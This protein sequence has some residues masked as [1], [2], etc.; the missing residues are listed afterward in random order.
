MATPRPARHSWQRLPGRRRLSVEQLSSG[1]YGVVVSSAT[2]AAA[3]DKPLETVVISVLTTVFVYWIAEQYARGLAHRATVGRLTASDLL[4][5]LRERYTMVEAT[6]VPL[7]VV[8][9]LGVL[10]V[11]ASVAVTVGLLV[12]VGTLAAVGILAARR[13]GL[14]ALGTALSGLIAAALGVAIVVLKLALH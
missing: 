6:F 9:A 14:S 10:G 2:M 5:G 3:G 7:L 4:H 11:T 13:S 8:V 12:A 1:I